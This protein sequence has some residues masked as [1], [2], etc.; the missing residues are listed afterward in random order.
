M[1]GTTRHGILVG[2]DGSAA[3]DAAVAWATHEAFMRRLPLTVLHVVA[4]V[5]VGWPVGQL[6]PDM[7]EW[8]QDNARHVVTQAREALTAN[9]GESETPTVC[10]EVVFSNVVPTLIAA[11]QEASMIVVGSQ[12]MGALG[13]LLLGS[14]STALLHHAHCPVAIVHS[15]NGAGPDSSAPVLVGIDGSPTSEEATALAFDEASRRGVDLLALHSWSDLG[16]FPVVTRDWSE[17]QNREEE[18][19]AERL[20]G[21]QEQYPDVRVHRSLVCAKPARWLLEQSEGAQLV[22]IG[23]HGRGGF[24]GML[25][26]SVSSAVAHSAK[27]PVIVV[28][29]S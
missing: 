28:R 19:L 4:P 6:Y 3:S 21:W 1:S 16:M 2:V 7:T 27:V 13:R 11:S 10:T 12:G 25:L 20:A 22:V 24:S 17:R 8:Q 5:V 23:S 29:R 26:G 14:I 18:V 9:L 15:D